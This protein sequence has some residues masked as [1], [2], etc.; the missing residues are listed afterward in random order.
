[1]ILAEGITLHLLE[2]Q[3]HDSMYLSL[4]PLMYFLFSVL[5]DIEPPDLTEHF[6][7]ALPL[8]IYLLHPL[9]IVLVRAGA[10]IT[11][12]LF[13]IDNSLLHFLAVTL[14]TF[15]FSWFL[16]VLKEKFAERKKK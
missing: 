16:L 7:K 1:M 14:S 15:M 2:V 6:P 10:K 9:F 12:L 8:L 4:V 3:R 13:F 5:L 11:G